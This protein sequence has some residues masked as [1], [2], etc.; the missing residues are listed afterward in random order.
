MADAS[1]RKPA[2]GRAAS[3]LAFSA[4]AQ[5]DQNCCALFGTRTVLADCPEKASKLK[6]GL[7]VLQRASDLTLWVGLSFCRIRGLKVKEFNLPRS[8][9]SL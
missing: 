4:A 5:L 9:R 8:E 6:R 2:A 1:G 3:L 7:I